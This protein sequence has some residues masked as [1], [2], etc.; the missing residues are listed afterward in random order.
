MTAF[1]ETSPRFALP[2]LVA[3]QAQ[4]EVFVNEAHALTDALLHCA[5]EGT[6]NTPPTSPAEGTAWLVGTAPTGAW[7]GQAGNLACRQAGQWLFA[8]PR[9]G[10]RLLN[11]ASGQEMRYF[12][13]WRVPV[14]PAAPTGGSVI[15]VQART[16]IGAIL[17]ALELAGAIPST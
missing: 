11:R 9:D 16:A 10:M 4:K 17:A 3:A 6:A 7:S 12:T 8:V 1:S 13:T 14:R 15:D 2:L 5:I